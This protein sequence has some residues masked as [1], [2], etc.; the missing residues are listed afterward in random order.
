MLCHERALRFVLAFVLFFCF[1][2]PSL[3]QSEDNPAQTG[4]ELPP[5]W[6][7]T[8]GGG[9]IEKPTYE[10]SNHSTFSP[11]PLVNVV[12]NDMVSLSMDGLNVYWDHDDFTL[13]CGL[14]YNGGRQANNSNSLFFDSDSRLRGLGN[15]DAALGVKAF[16]SYDFKQFELNTSVTKLTG[17]NN[18][19]LLADADLSASIEITKQLIFKPHI[20]ATWANQ[21]YMQTYFGVTSEQSAS[22]RFSRFHAS[23]GIKDVVIGL[24]GSFWFNKNWF[25]TTNIDLTH[26][27][28]DAARSPI[29]FSDEQV[30]LTAMIGYHF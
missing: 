10:G 16:A 9:A 21:D 15:I 6:D 3:A 24:N 5:K 12:W 26:L 7:I 29:S 11:V 27:V 4:N 1:F 30:Q 14:V 25:V 20:G 17:T 13:G 22:S 23:P 8:L 19:G 2:A 18:H 28:G